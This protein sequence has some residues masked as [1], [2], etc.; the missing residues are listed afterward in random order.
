[1]TQRQIIDYAHQ[2]P[3]VNCSGA[4]HGTLCQH[5]CAAIDAATN[6][7]THRAGAKAE[8]MRADLV[9]LMNQA[10]A[11]RDEGM[12]A[13]AS[14]GA[15]AAFVLRQ[16]ILLPPDGCEACLNT[17][18]VPSSVMTGTMTKCPACAGRAEG[19]VAS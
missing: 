17:R 13:H 19:A 7:A 6:E 9:N 15:K 18:E 8:K 2:V 1:M 10:K 5:I 4:V 16:L 11:N 14:G 3:G 12:F